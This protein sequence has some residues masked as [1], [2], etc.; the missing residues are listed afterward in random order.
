MPLEIPKVPPNPKW[1]QPCLYDKAS[2][3]YI[4]SPDSKKQ[5]THEQENHKQEVEK[6]LEK[7]KKGQKTEALSALDTRADIAVSALVM[8]GNTQLNL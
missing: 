7:W 5:K 3:K 1:P 4:S 8:L 6:A 2:G